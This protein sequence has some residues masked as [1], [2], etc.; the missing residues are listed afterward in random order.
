VLIAP[1][2]TVSGVPVDLVLAALDS[3]GNIDTN[4]HGTVHITTSDT[5]SGVLLPADYTF[6]SG[7]AGIHAFP[8]G[9]TLITP[10][11]QVLMATDITSGI[12]G[13]ATIVVGASPGARPRRAPTEWLF[14]WAESACVNL[15]HTN[16]VSLPG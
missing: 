11:L 8:G 6:T 1:P 9:S 14:V 15:Q 16:R 12:T 5:G 2:T 7:D 13:S 3:F 4:Y 10:G